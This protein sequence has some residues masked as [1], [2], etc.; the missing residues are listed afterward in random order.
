MPDIF[1][2]V[3]LSETIEIGD[4]ATTVRPIQLGQCLQIVQRY[5]ALRE[6]LDGSKKE[7]SYG[8]ILNTGAVPAICAAGC[9]RFADE[10]AE[11]HFSALDADT[12]SRFLAP[13]LRLTMPRGI[14]PFLMSLGGFA[15]V[16]TGPP[17]PKLM[18][19]EEIA[20]R[21]VKNSGNSSH[22]F[23]PNI[24]EQ[25]VNAISGQ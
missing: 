18:T 22:S 6:F 25:S 5:P 19:R 24:E 1:D 9:G 17:E 12:Q 8:E 3:P 13:I 14:A 16:L 4:T 2:L 23:S 7:V 15:E 11:A 21:L 10:D 20:K